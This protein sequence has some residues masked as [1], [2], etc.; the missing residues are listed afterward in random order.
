MTT[1][2]RGDAV[3]PQG[4]KSIEVGAKVLRA[5]EEGRGPMAL[6]SVARASG[7]HPAKTHRYLVSLVRMGL[8]AQSVTTGLYDLGPAS[9]RLGVEALRR[10]D[11]VSAASAHAVSLRDRTGH[12]VNVAVWSDAGPALVRW[13]TGEHELPI[14]IRVGSTL[15]LLDSA[16][17][18][19]FLAYLAPSVIS[20][21]LKA[22]QRR[23]TTRVL[24]AK[25]LEAL[26]A[27]TRRAGIALTTDRMIFGLSALATPVFGPDGNLEVAVGMV[28]PSGM[29]NPSEAKRLGGLLRGA[30]DRA[31]DELGYRTRPEHTP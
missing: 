5:L 12:T 1:T 7:L 25:E 22:Q 4:I 8:A 24:P 31:S 2:E 9:R 26:R 17:G 10:T 14:A 28:L 20:R 21:A 29:M 11:V 6:S 23:G 3:L 15:P 13:D 30:T 16:V 19:V 27:E 18:H